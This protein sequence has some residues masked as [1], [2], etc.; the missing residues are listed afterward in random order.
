[1]SRIEDFGAHLSGAAKERWRSYREAMSRARREAGDPLTAPLSE[2]FPEP[3]YTR[4]IEDGADAWVIAFVRAAREQIPTRPRDPYRAVP[5]SR[6]VRALR[7][8]SADLIEGVIDRGRVEARLADPGS[9]RLREGLEGRMALYLALG[10]ECSLRGHRLT[11]TAYQVLDEVRHDPPLMRWEVQRDRSGGR[12]EVLAF[13]HT[14]E[15]AIDAFRDRLRAEA[16]APVTRRA[17]IEIYS[18]RG[19]PE[20][21]AVIGVKNGPHLI[22][23]ARLPTVRAA[24]EHL[25]ENR[26]TL[27]DRL[28]QMRDLPPERGDENRDR[29]GPARREGEVSPER[30]QDLFGFRGVQFGNYV[31]GARRQADLNRAHDAL[32]DLASVIGC[33]PRALSLG[34]TLGLAFGARGRGG[35]GAAAAHFEPDQ[36]VINLTKT[37]GAGSLAHE[38]F[39][40]LDNHLARRSGAR[41]TQYASELNGPF[42][43]LIGRLTTG[44]RMAERSALLDRVRSSPYYT[45]RVEMTARGF[46]TFVISE[47][48]SRGI[49]NDYLANVISETD[50]ETVAALRGQPPGGYPYPLRTELV[51]VR[52]AY[53]RLFAAPELRAALLLG[54]DRTEAAPTS[55]E[56]PLPRSSAPVPSPE[57]GTGREGGSPRPGPWETPDF[58]WG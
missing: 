43:G 16:G 51:A 18:W 20:R 55:P 19:R 54:Q 1:M 29:S 14:R 9:A 13:A 26:D 32:L 25:R 57:K 2:A 45:T 34:G 47:L 53:Q 50:F 41:S 23:L 39:H 35:K 48:G 37:N 56:R 15:G 52:D 4:L 28:R 24:Q 3:P 38:W 11:R 46:E 22:E 30:F 8:I 12:A 33:A 44:T 5:W 10:H 21:G 31:E 40:A 42:A 27:E 17:P 58:D 49:T 6:T 7:D 36:I